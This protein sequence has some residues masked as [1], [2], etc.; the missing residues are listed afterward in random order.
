MGGE[1]ISDLTAGSKLELM[2]AGVVAELGAWVSGFTGE[3]SGVA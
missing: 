3:M 1:Y 2:K